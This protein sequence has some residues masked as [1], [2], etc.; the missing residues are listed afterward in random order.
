MNGFNQAFCVQFSGGG[1]DYY[2]QG[3]RENGEIQYG[4]MMGDAMDCGSLE[5]AQEVAI[6]VSERYAQVHAEAVVLNRMAK[7]A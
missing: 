2:L 6:E 7:A 3:L 5:R 1:W 4:P